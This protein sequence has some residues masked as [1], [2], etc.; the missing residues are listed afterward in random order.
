MAKLAPW[1]RRLQ[2][3]DTPLTV[4]AETFPDI[5]MIATTWDTWSTEHALT[6]HA[7]GFAPRL[8]LAEPDV[9]DVLGAKYYVHG[10]PDSTAQP[11]A[12]TLKILL[13]RQN[14]ADVVRVHGSGRPIIAWRK[15]EGVFDRLPTVV[16]EGCSIAEAN[17][18]SRALAAAIP[19]RTVGRELVT[20]RVRVK[21][22]TMNRIIAAAEMDQRAHPDGSPRGKSLSAFC[23]GVLIEAV[24]RIETAA[25][26]AVAVEGLRRAQETAPPG[27][28][29]VL[30][31]LGPALPSH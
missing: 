28:I 19:K 4:L 16:W 13:Q 26:T 24:E 20:L 8:R 2:S 10:D 5:D 17:A 1:K 21:R 25:E 18:S 30:F 15:H 12:E 14:T 22:R 11:L 27:T 29:A 7:G 9:V 6:K 31:P 23:L 3:S